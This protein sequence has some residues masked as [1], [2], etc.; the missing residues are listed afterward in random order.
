MYQ[1]QP[2]RSSKSGGNPFVH[3]G[4]EANRMTVATAVGAETPIY[5]AST[6]IPCKVVLRSQYT[7]TVVLMAIAEGPR[8]Y[9]PSASSQP[10]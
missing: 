5:A 8:G 3:G 1:D 10:F 9:Q 2:R 6:A 7:S 4:N